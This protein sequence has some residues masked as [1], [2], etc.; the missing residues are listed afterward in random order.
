MATQVVAP[1]DMK[2]QIVHTAR[3]S[4]FTKLANQTVSRELGLKRASRGMFTARRV[5]AAGRWSL[6]AIA[7]GEGGR[8][9]F[10][11]LLS[12]TLSLRTHGGVL[13]LHAHDAVSQVPLSAETLVEAS[14]ELEFL[15]F[16]ALDT[17]RAR[18]Y[19][20]EPSKQIV[21]LDA[22]EA[23]VVGQ[24]PRSYFDYRDLGVAEATNRRLELQV[25]RAQRSR[26][27]GTGWHSH[28]MA[29]M[30]YGLSGWALLGVE[31]AAEPVLK[32]PGDALCIP[33]D[34][35]HNAGSFSDDYWALQLQIPPD[36]DT[37]AR[38]APVGLA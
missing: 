33:A 27:G 20:P 7:S 24:G 19:L 15:E 31:G 1:I 16:Q 30:T 10:I 28:N 38:P 21:A 23:H 12:G 2:L 17:E 29:Q 25:V 5:K 35:V 3:L 22:P 13:A 26:D 4:E 9:T 18:Q 14:P 8:F 32:E 11:Y 37:H 36:Y 34:C 6:D